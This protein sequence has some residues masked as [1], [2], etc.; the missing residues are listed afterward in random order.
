MGTCYGHYR[1][2]ITVFSGYKGVMQSIGRGVNAFRQ[3]HAAPYADCGRQRKY[4]SPNFYGTR[5]GN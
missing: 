4:V 2:D 1:H 5:R 3:K